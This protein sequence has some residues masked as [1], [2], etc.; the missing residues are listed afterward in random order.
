MEIITDTK[1]TLSDR[2]NS[3][4]QSI[5]FQH[6]H[7]HY[8]FS[9]VMNKILHAV[10]VKI[11]TSRCD[12][13]SLSPLLKHTTSLCWLVSSTLATINVQQSSMNASGCPFLCMEKFTYTSLLHL[14]FHVRSHSVRTATLSIC[15][16]VRKPYRGI[17]TGWITGLRPMG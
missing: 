3:T 17:W 7:H 10:F 4:L 5:I 8:A 12:L 9:P 13:L 15:L 14:N 1:I 2:R 11:C 6:S 16:G